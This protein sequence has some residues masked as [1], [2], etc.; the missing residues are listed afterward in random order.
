MVRGK[1]NLFGVW[2]WWSLGERADM[3]E[4]ECCGQSVSQSRWLIYGA[5]STMYTTAEDCRLFLCKTNSLHRRLLRPNG[6]LL[7]D[8]LNRQSRGHTFNL[9]VDMVGYNMNEWMLLASVRDLFLFT[10]C[11]GSS[12]TTTKSQPFLCY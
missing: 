6:Y 8:K 2:R 7:S 10:W 1:Y 4:E 5:S 3:G 9:F 11:S 12:A